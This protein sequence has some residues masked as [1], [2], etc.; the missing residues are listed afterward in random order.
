MILI[1]LSEEE[2]NILKQ[3]GNTRNSD[4]NERCLYILLSDE[5]KSVPETAGQTKR[6]GH[7]VRFRLKEYRKGGTERL[8][9][10]SPPGRPSVKGVRIYPIIPEIVPKSPSEY[11]YIGAGR[12]ISMIADYLKRDGIAVS[13]GTIKRVLKKTAGFAKGFRKQ[14]RPVSPVMRRKKRGFVKLSTE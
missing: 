6:N 14:S 3:F 7:T 4:L 2:R 11:G 10:L 1:R 9:G 5:G 12:T 13:A 8:K